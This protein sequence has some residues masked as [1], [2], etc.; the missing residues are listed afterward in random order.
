MHV[1]CAY[2]YNLAYFYS[3]FRDKPLGNIKTIL[4]IMLGKWHYSF[5]YVTPKLDLFPTKAIY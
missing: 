5:D 1:L 2:A 4:G 3:F